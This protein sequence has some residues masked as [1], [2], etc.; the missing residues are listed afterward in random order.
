MFLLGQILSSDVSGTF[1]LKAA[2]TNFGD[3][4][5]VFFSLRIPVLRQFCPIW[6]LL[7]SSIIP[8]N[9]KLNLI[10]DIHEKWTSQNFCISRYDKTFQSKQ[11]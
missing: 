5:I 9:T 1:L 10:V 7:K 4:N 8:R 3:R 11:N 2:K 6:F